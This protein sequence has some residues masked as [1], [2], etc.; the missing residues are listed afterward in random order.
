M[1]ASYTC[2]FLEG[3]P[4]ILPRADGTAV[5]KPVDL[6]VRMREADGRLL[7]CGSARAV[8]DSSLSTSDFREVDGY[9]PY[10]VTDNVTGPT[11]RKDDE[12]W[13]VAD[14]S[15]LRGSRI[16]SGGCIFVFSLSGSNAELGVS[17][18]DRHAC[19]QGG[20]RGPDRNRR[21]GR[22]RAGPAGRQ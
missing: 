4:D 12:G 16:R 22:R 2:A 19:R 5:D 6:L 7:P 14:A 11:A 1:A 15:G 13:D 21:L 8:G 17:V 10:C 18:S 20:R 9:E 3:S